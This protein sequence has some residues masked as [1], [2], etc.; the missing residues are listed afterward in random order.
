[1]ILH[2]LQYHLHWKT[3]YQNHCYSNHQKGPWVLKVN[4]SLSPKHQLINNI[5]NKANRLLIL[6]KSSLFQHFHLSEI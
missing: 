4:K 3:A 2:S 5:I 1:M 6:T